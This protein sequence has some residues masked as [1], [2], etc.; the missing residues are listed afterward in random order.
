MRPRRGTGADRPTDPRA[1]ERARAALCRL[2]TGIPGA[3]GGPPAAGHARSCAACRCFVDALVRAR[4]WLEGGGAARAASPGSRD[5]RRAL[6]REVA[7][8][9][10]RDVVGGGLSWPPRQALERSRD[11]RRLL[12]LRRALRR[13]HEQGTREQGPVG[14][15]TAPVTVRPARSGNRTADAFSL[16]HR[17]DPQGVDVALAYLGQLVRRGER[18]AADVAADRLLQRLG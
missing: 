1:C 5:M 6:A 17:L 15:A 11:L 16:A 2:A 13:P 8:R 9:L 12:A 14:R 4:A 10:A 3:A 18:P 7:A